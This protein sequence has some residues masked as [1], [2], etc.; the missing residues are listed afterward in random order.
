MIETFTS[1]I[2]PGD[3]VMYNFNT[4]ADL[5]TDGVYNIDYECLLLNDQNTSNNLF[6]GI[7]ENFVSPNPPTTIDDTICL[8][9]TAFLEA[10]T[11]QG[12]INWYSD[13]NGTAPINTNAVTPNIT[14]TYYAEVQA[15]NFYK[16]DFESYPIGSLIAQSSAFWTTLSG[17]G[18]G[19]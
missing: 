18:G 11:N 4:T 13:A 17:A 8:G 2:N 19:P 12:L 9:D 16:D 10:T 14:T 6:S 15:S 5:S 7:N 3:T 1:T